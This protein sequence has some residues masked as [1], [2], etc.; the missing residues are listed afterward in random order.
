MTEV[1][2]DSTGAI[3]QR[4][5]QCY[6]PLRFLGLERGKCMSVIGSDWQTKRLTMREPGT[7]WAV[8]LMTLKRAFPHGVKLLT[9]FN[10]AVPDFPYA[11][12]TVLVSDSVREWIFLTISSRSLMMKLAFFIVSVI[13][14]MSHISN[15]RVGFCKTRVRVEGVDEEEM[16][17]TCMF[18][19]GS[20]SAMILNHVSR[21]IPSG[22][23][24]V[25]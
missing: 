22:P 1:D 15:K 11:L 3:D 8:L 24:P 6:T 7:A 23:R 10:R 20:R 5:S 14:M 25:M 12:M 18:V 13:M 17:L 9:M 2:H 4:P 16:L 21:L 19:I